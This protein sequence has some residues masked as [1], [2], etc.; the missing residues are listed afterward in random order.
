MRVFHRL[1]VEQGEVLFLRGEL[2]KQQNNMEK[3]RQ[4]LSKSLELKEQ[5]AKEREKKLTR[6]LEALK[7]ERDFNLR[8]LEQASEVIQRLRRQKPET[9]PESPKSS[10]LKRPTLPPSQSLAKKPRL[11]SNIDE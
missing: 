6:E 4:E 2:A 8:E 9:L 3:T 5:E 1:F 11:A 7:S 10:S